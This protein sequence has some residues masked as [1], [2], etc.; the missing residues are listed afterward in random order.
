MQKKI[1]KK[2]LTKCRCIRYNTKAACAVMA[3]WSSGQDGGLSRRKREFDSPTG[4]HTAH[5]SSYS[6]IAQSV[7]H[8]AVNRRV[9]GSSPTWGA[10]QKAPEN[11]YFKP[12]SGAFTF[13]CYSV[14]ALVFCVI[15]AVSIK[16]A[17]QNASQTEKQKAPTIR[18]FR[19]VGAS[20]YYSVSL[21]AAS[22]T[23]SFAAASNLVKN[24]GTGAPI[25]AAF[26]RMLPNSVRIY[27]TST[28]GRISTV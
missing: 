1:C 3:R 15:Y 17:S 23:F 11:G 6:S 25:A 16:Y 8:A 2:V 14:F 12:N 24:G 26:S 5:G 18:A 19:T 13:P 28:T 22:S 4:H 10:I 9:V 21:S 27:Q 7:E 20:L